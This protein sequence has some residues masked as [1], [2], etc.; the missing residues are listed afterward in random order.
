[1]VRRSL[2]SLADAFAHRELDQVAHLVVFKVVQADAAF[3]ARTHFTHV[4]GFALERADTHVLDDVFGSASDSRLRIAARLTIPDHTPGDFANLR[5]LEDLLDFSGADYLVFV[6]RFEQPRERLFDIFDHL[7][8]CIVGA[9]FNGIRFREAVRRVIGLHVE[10]DHNCLRGD[11][12]VD[13]VLGNGA[14]FGV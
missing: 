7:I 11:R 1:M 10:A 12:Q 9:H 2:E 14:R 4:F 13:I 8:D 3:K 5:D 6:D